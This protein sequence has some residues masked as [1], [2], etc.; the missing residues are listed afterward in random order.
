[1]MEEPIRCWGI[2]SLTEDGMHI[3]MLD[4]DDAG[5][6]LV[7][8]HI[9][10]AQRKFNLSDFHIIQGGKP[11]HFHTYCTSKVTLEEYLDIIKYF[12]ENADC[13]DN[14]KIPLIKWEVKKTVL[15]VFGKDKLEYSQT[16]ESV[17]QNRREHSKAHLNFLKDM[18]GI[19]ISPYTH[20][21]N[22]EETIVDNYPT[23]KP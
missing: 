21:D 17:C 23:H 3:V 18:H 11:D 4:F 10:K 5:L 12:E 19:D 6:T 2:A 16:I 14:F 22:H 8:K 7:I 9:L 15:R 20:I 1:M 13:D